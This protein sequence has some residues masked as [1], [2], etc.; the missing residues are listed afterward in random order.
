MELG[1]IPMKCPLTHHRHVGLPAQTAVC[2]SVKVFVRAKEKQDPVLTM[3][4]QIHVM[5]NHVGFSAAI[6]IRHIC[7][8]VALSKRGHDESRP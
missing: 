3:Q 4:T 1:H 7:G 8:I 2:E 6:L 5:L